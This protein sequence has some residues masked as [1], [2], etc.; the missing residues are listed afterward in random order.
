MKLKL[1][2]Q[3]LSVKAEMRPLNL[4]LHKTVSLILCAFYVATDSGQREFSMVVS[5][6][7]S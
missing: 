5:K 7:P 2:L 3:R 4:G 6:R 1:A